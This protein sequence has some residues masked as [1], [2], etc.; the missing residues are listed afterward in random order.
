M[1]TKAD[2]TGTTT[3][4]WDFENRLASVALPGSGGTV[5][6]KY[7]P[8]GRRAQKSSLLG[9]TNY[10]YDG[11]DSLEEVD[12]TGNV[13]ARYTQGQG[14]DEP[15]A[16]VRSGTTSYYEADG[17]GSITS[18]SNSS[19]ALAN[20]YT[21]DSF[22]NLT[23]STGTLTNPLRY[24]SRELDS[25]TG[26]YFYRAR[27]YDQANGRFLSED[28][29]GFAAG[30]N[31]YAYVKNDATDFSDP[32]GWS[33]QCLLNPKSRCAKIFQKA[34]GM[35]PSEYNNVA[36]NI[37]W[38]YSPNANT[39]NPLTWNDIAQNGDDTP[40][41]SA[42]T[43]TSTE[44]ATAAP[45]GPRPAPVVLGPDWFL[46]TVARQSAVMLHES[47]HSI[48]G[49]SDPRVFGAFSK[50]GLPHAAYDATHGANTDEFTQW[51]LAGCPGVQ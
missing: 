51:L 46:D 41:S 40:I 34:F 42:F 33:R 6:F 44:A 31:K 50:L 19:G 48:T 1:L 22:G 5:I 25:E 28:P 14:I 49:W 13:L 11:A 15:L 10:L 45:G 38:F 26:A 23:A 17:L 47:V 4:T 27:Y 36:N 7:D 24:T 39:F 37:P 35:S 43:G 2:S 12:T 3:Y 30:M 32:T 20:T 29:I 8:F 21:Y 18:L 16:E 9:T